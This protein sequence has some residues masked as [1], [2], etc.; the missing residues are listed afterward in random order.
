MPPFKIESPT[1]HILAEDQVFLCGSTTGLYIPPDSYGET[2]RADV[3]EVLGRMCA[4]CR[5]A[6][7]DLAKEAI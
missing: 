4:T 3:T 5:A 6:Y 7:G 1:I 2:V